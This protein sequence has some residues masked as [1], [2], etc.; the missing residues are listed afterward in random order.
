MNFGDVSANLAVVRSRIARAGGSVD[1]IQIVA[2]TKGL[3]T[4]AVSAAIDAGLSCA[5]EN[6]AQELKTK[7]SEMVAA[8][9]QPPRWHFIGRLQRNKVRLVADV[10]D[11]W[12]SVDSTALLDEVAKRDPRAS[13][14]IQ[15]NLTDD[16]ARSGC[17]WDDVPLLVDRARDLELDVHGLM[18][19]GPLAE[20]EEARLGFRRLA[21]TA[22]SLE[23]S[24]VSMGMTSDLEVAVQEGT[25]MLRIGSALFGARPQS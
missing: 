11:V 10:V 2:V 21:R 25:S 22:A 18:A 1:A 23:V 4:D 15:V 5:G 20:P 9:R 16:P 24:E 6:Y 7:H 8:G 3:G 14:M 12:Q 13:V 19:V 17:G